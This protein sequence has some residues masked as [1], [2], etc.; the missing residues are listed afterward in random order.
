MRSHAK[1]MRAIL[2]VLLVVVMIIGMIPP[3]EAQ[4]ADYQASHIQKLEDA[5]ALD[6]TKYV[7]SAVMFEL[8]DTISSDD[9]IS[10][11]ITLDVINLMDAYEGTDKTMS[12][13]EFALSSEEAE[14]V[15]A[16]VRERKAQI[17]SAMDDQGIAYN[18]GE[19]Y[20]TL[21]TG[22][23]IVIEAADFE[24]ACMSLGQ[25]ASAVI[26]EVYEAAET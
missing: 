12:F 1:V 17:L 9:E 19:D 15:K 25:G 2:S 13:S 23:E 16:Q 26:G 8:P 6:Y 11:I 10:V 7:D 3:I 24:A 4:A 5:P 14:A 22:F 21:L 18:L 20:D